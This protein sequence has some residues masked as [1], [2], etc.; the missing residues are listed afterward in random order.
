MGTSLQKPLPKDNILRLVLIAMF[1]A[2]C[3][4]IIMFRIPIADQFVHAGN[5]VCILAALLLG[6]WQGGLAGSIGM[7]L[8]DL[9]FYPSSVVKTLILKFGIGL[10]TGLIFRY[11]KTHPDRS[12]RLGLG[13]A[14]GVSLASGAVVLAIYLQSSTHSNGLLIPS[15]FLLILG[16]VL[17]GILV[18]SCFVRSFSHDILYAVFGA[19]IGVAFNVVGEFTW[20]FVENLLTGLTVGGAVTATLVKIPATF[21][22]GSFSVFLAVLLYLPVRTAL[23]KA[24]LGSMLV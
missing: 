8:N 11:G 24:K 13:I 5:A 7:G 15:I 4:V 19:T 12:P 9:F 16:G 1:A 2:I 18:A 17:A 6:G 20:R 3:F 14:S 22:N 10:F 21:L 23:Q